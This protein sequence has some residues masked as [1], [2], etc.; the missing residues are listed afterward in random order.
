MINYVKNS[1]LKFSFKKTLPEKDKEK[2]YYSS[3][4]FFFFSFSDCSLANSNSSFVCLNFF[5]LLL[6]CDLDIKTA[7]SSGSSLGRKNQYPTE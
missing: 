7:H 5:I 4:S 2:K 3:D 1:P 6:D